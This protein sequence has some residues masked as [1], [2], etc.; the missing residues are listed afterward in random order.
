MHYLLISKY[1]HLMRLVDE[2]QK[3]LRHLLC[4]SETMPRG[5]VVPV[6]IAWRASDLSCARNY[7][8]HLLCCGRTNAS[9]TL[10]R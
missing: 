1:V 8:R 6:S 5:G 7:L 10:R 4:N 2:L 9:T 3:C